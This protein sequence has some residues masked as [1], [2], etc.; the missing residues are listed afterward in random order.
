MKHLKLKILLNKLFKFAPIIL[1]ILVALFL[2]LKNLDRRA[3]FDAD[4]EEI[5]GRA[6]ELL[7]GQP[8]LLGP[9]T[10][11][12]AFSIGPGFTYLWGLFSIFTDGDP[13]AGAYSSVFLGVG[14]IFFVYF[15]TRKIYSEK[16]ALIL[17]FVSTV[18]LTLIIW[19]Q[20]PWAPSLFYL[21]E[22]LAIYGVYISDKTPI[23]VFIAIS[24]LVIGF[25]AHFAI[26]LLLPAILIYWLIFRPKFERKWAVYSLTLIVAGFLPNIVFDATHH[27][28]NFGR[29][30]SVFKLAVVGTAPPMAKII[31]TLVSNS[32][33]F[34]YVFFPVILRV[35]IFVI[36]ILVCV[37]GALKAG[38]YR[39]A[40]ILSLLFL[41]IPFTF[42]LF[43]RSNFSEYYL[44]SALPPF[45]I[46]SGYVFEKVNKYYL[47]ITWKLR[48][49]RL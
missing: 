15:F 39:K 16:T 10:S 2:R 47:I 33:S 35:I 11:L 20:S 13:I 30:L 27:F 48:I 6:K 12:G 31:M 23:G 4:Q 41:F 25:Q 9:K 7:S 17:S 43:Y 37:I 34:Y 40:I 24:G 38:K 49:F 42:F 45:I 44:M 18:S 19:D 3:P 14:F 5:A 46:L 36:T 8:V 32:A 28:V 22:L 21:A 1:I 26:F 29:L